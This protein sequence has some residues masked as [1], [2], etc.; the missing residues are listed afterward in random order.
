MSQPFPL[1]IDAYAHI[2][3]PRYRE[4]LNKVAPGECDTKV[5]PFPALWDLGERFRIMDRYGELMQVITLGWPPIEEIADPVKAVELCQMVND[6][7]AELVQKYPA[8]FVAGIAH[9]PMNNMD[10]ALK[11]LDR[12]IVDLRL[13]GVQVYSPV[14]DKPLDSPEFWPLYEKMEQ[15]DLP[16]FIH[17]MREGTNYPDYRTEK[18]SKY[19]IAGTYGWPYETTTAMT[20]LVFSG[21]LEKYPGLKIVTH[22]CGGMVPFF[23]ERQSEFA[24]LRERSSGDQ[25]KLTL[26]PI[27]YFKKFYADTALY[28]NT[29]GLM[30]GY[31]FFGPDK[32]VFGADMPLGDTQRGYRNYRQTLNAIDAMPISPED[33]KKILEGNARK[34]MRLPL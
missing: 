34:L 22:H 19:H 1:R 14:N 5:M 18:E 12:A 33:K 16:I 25:R 17:P 26:H 4:I 30:C 3:P 21:V 24:D 15:Y 2:V 7:M 27:E 6:E 31:A 10:A 23:A 20:R 32:M 28:G 13:R 29:P 9:L 8:R 11:E